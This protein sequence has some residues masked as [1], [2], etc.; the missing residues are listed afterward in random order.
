[1]AVIYN[2]YDFYFN[3]WLNAIQNA[4]EIPSKTLVL[5]VAKFVKTLKTQNV[6]N[7]LSEVYIFSGLSNYNSIF[8]KLKYVSNPVL[9]NSGFVQSDYKSTGQTAGLASDGVTSKLLDLTLPYN[10][11]TPGN[12]SAGVY[13]TKRAQCFYSTIIGREGI[14]GNTGWGPDVQNGSNYSEFRYYDNIGYSG[15]GAA[16]IPPGNI[17]GGAAGLFAVS[18][19]GGLAI[20]RASNST[21]TTSW[22]PGTLAGTTAYRIGGNLGGGGLSASTISFGFIGLGLTTDQLIILDSAVNTMMTDFNCN[23]Y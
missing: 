1:M 17:N 5:S 11:F 9:I 14:G 3:N 4:G 12:R 19:S 7:S 16:A 21:A 10:T 2:G 20:G 18:E 22:T 15:G 6:W 8:Q 13:E 23:V